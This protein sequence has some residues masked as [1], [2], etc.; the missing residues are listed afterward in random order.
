[1]PVELAA[2]RADSRAAADADRAKDAYERDGGLQ[3]R[4]GEVYAA[5]AAAQWCGPWL[6]AG[7][8]VDAASLAAELTA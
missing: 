1:M 8:D 4:T 3:R 7:A 5:L 6:V 2:A